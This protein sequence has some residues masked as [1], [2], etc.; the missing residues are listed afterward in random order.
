MAR[1]LDIITLRGLS[2]AGRHGVFDSERESE[3]P[4]HVDISLWVDTTEAAHSD[5]IDQTVSYADIAEE[6][7]AVLSGPSVSLLETLAQ[8]VADAALAHPR[9]EGVEVTVHKP[10]APLAQQFSDVLVTIRRGTCDEAPLH[11]ETLQ[12][13]DE[14]EDARGPLEK[15]SPTLPPLPPVPASLVQRP[16]ADNTSAVREHPGEAKTAGSSN[17]R[18]D[19]AIVLPPRRTSTYQPHGLDDAAQTRHVVLALGGNEG[20]APVT[21][22]AAVGKLID[23]DGFEVDNVSPLLR[24]QAVIDEGT[25]PQRDYWNAVVLGRTTLDAEELLLRCQGFEAEL[26]RVRHEHWGPRTVDIDIV[27]VEGTTCHTPTLTLPHPYV[28]QRAFVL[29]PWN[30][31]DPLAELVDAHGNATSVAQLALAAPD[32]NGIRDAVTDWLDDPA[33]VMD[34]SDRVL[35]SQV[36]EPLSKLDLLPPESKIGLRPSESGTDV[37]WRNLWKQWQ[38]SPLDNSERHEQAEAPAQASSDVPT[39]VSADALPTP[40]APSDAARREQEDVPAEAPVDEPADLPADQPINESADEPLAVDEPVAGSQQGGYEL[41]EP[42]VAF[43]REDM[44]DTSEI[45]IPSS[46]LR[47]RSVRWVP[48]RSEHNSGEGKRAYTDAESDPDAGA[49]DPVPEGDTRGRRGAASRSTSRRGKAHVP[50]LPDWNFQSSSPARI[51]D[52]ADEA[53]VRRRSILDPHIADQFPHGPLPDDETTTTSV[54]R[55][56]TV[57]PTV[58]GHIPV[59]RRDEGQAQ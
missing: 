55:G 3:Q 1:K 15:S 29:V 44:S 52:D 27:T 35:A 57:R 47:R 31:A 9:V 36:D 2:A 32:R 46:L 58:T 38:S 50:A 21:L 37:L 28:H 8:R 4:F 53:P 24:T 19:Y 33:S 23:L 40:P 48:V 56:R 14:V 13:A 20:N 22:A 18:V 6:A 7:V 41:P 51:I 42:P 45:M 49:D 25:A 34:E 17:R 59:I 30:M 12:R 11:V 10:M 54:V 16:V 5:D 43:T 26:G 39:D